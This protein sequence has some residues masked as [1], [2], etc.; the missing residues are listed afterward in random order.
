MNRIFIISSLIIFT[1]LLH[2]QSECD[3]YIR[4]IDSLI[5]K[6]DLNM[7]YNMPP[8]SCE[9]SLLDYTKNKGYIGDS[10]DFY[11]IY[12]LETLSQYGSSD[13]VR[14]NAVNELLLRAYCTNVGPYYYLRKEDFNQQARNRL[15]MLLQKQYSPEEEIRYIK[16]YTRSIYE[17]TIYISIL[18]NREVENKKISYEKAKDSLNVSFINE[19]KEKLYKKGYSIN[20]PL[21][22][23]WLNMKD[24]IP[25]LD[26][27]QQVDGD[28][29]VM[30]AL[31]RLG[32]KKYQQ[33]FLDRR[34]NDMN[35][36]FYIGT[37]DLIAKYGDKLYSKEYNYFIQPRE[38][39]PIVYNVIIDLQKNI[40]NF[41]RLITGDYLFKQKQIDALS[42]DVL[43]K[44]R[45]WMKENKG[46]Y[47]ISS[48]FVPYFNLDIYKAN[49]LITPANNA[50]K[51]Q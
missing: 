5:K 12:I 15:K 20:L 43:E 7:R 9:E 37:Q 8:K 45:Q 25:L 40:S 21:L 11:I 51:V 29:S 42:P 19:Y 36:N 10:T 32:N 23:G 49:N 1:T 17:D 16:Y 27:I 47:I 34:G 28:I 35:I 4:Q 22:I 33:Y 24:C 46:K 48:D 44:A 13:S 30:L 6:K 26:S 39:I 38:A 14:E 2:A 3:T 41:P 18:A 50:E 31:A